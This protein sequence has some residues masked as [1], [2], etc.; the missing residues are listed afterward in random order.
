MLFVQGAGV[1][2][3][4]GTSFLLL[5]AWKKLMGVMKA[6]ERCVNQGAGFP[7][8]AQLT[9]EARPR[10]DHDFTGYDWRRGVVVRWS[11]DYPVEVQHVELF[12]TAL[13]LPSRLLVKVG[14]RSGLQCELGIT[15]SFSR[16]ESG[17]K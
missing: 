2:F 12:A 8:N 17:V 6:C 15:S 11:R 10:S 13:R 4:L 1:Q 3:L 9:L 5:R 7:C 14:S 16:V